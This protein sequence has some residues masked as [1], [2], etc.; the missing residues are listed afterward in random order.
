MIEYK[1][2]GDK[3]EKLDVFNSSTTLDGKKYGRGLL[4][5]NMEMKLSGSEDGYYTSDF[6]DTFRLY[7]YDVDSKTCTNLLASD[8][9]NDASSG[10]A[11]I[12]TSDSTK[13][14]RWPNKV[15]ETTQYAL[16]AKTQDIATACT[17][18]GSNKTVTIYWEYYLSLAF[19][20][21]GVVF[22]HNF[23][24]LLA[25]VKTKCR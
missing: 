18:T 5:F 10:L 14:F 13:A 25:S 19:F 4:G 22:S 7:L 6:E 11:E 21:I 12:S 9:G 1:G 3:L 8:W 2:Y 16:P 20:T 23:M 17:P 15:S 24:P